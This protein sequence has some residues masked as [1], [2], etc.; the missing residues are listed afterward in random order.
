MIQPAR[1]QRQIASRRDCN[2]AIDIDS[3]L[4]KGLDQNVTGAGVDGCVLKPHVNVR[5][6]RNGVTLDSNIADSID[7]CIM[8]ANASGSGF[9]WT[10]G[11][12]PDGQVAG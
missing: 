6:F 9:P 2:R 5:V 4:A 3:T 12:A 11:L 10:V 1:D 7:V 8:K